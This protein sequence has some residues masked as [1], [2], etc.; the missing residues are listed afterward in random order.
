[1]TRKGRRIAVGRTKIFIAGFLPVLFKPKGSGR[2]ALYL[3][4][5]AITKPEHNRSKS[6]VIS[7]ARSADD[8]V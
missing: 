4:L 3:L 1:M 6:R 7:S 5:L 8:F 2:Q